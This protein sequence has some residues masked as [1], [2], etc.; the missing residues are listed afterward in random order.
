MLA[1][2]TAGWEAY[3]QLLVDVKLALT[4]LWLSEVQILTKQCYNIM[5]VV[6]QSPADSAGN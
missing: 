4:C 5:N 1:A 3:E 6:L 2:L